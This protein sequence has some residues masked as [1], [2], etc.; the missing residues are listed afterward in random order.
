[1]MVDVDDGKAS[2]SGSRGKISIFNYFPNFLV[3]K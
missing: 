3:N 2:V 1:M